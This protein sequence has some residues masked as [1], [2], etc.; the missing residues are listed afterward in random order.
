[1][2]VMVKVRFNS[3]EERFE[4]FGNNR[5]LLYLPFEHDED[6]EMIIIAS[7]S[8]HLGIPVRRIAFK[9]YDHYKDMVFDIL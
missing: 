9:K 5:Y 2:Q 3:S 1:M 4:N 8:K 6:A 7:L